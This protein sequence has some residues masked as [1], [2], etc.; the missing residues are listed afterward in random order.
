MRSFGMD[1]WIVRSPCTAVPRIRLFC[2][3]YAGGGTLTYRSWAKAL[4]EDVELCAVQLP[5]RE[6]RLGDPLVRSTSRMIDLLASALRRHIDRPFAFFGHSMGAVLAYEAARRL[7]A[8]TGHEPR[9]LVVSGHRPPH[10]ASHKPPLHGLPDE[11]FIAG[12]KA[13]NGTP[14]EIF[15]HADL[16]QLILPMLRAD[17][18]LIETYAEL[19]GPRLSCPVIALGG[20]ADTDVPIADIASWQSVTRGSFKSIVIPGD[21]FYVNTARDKLLEI[22]LNELPALKES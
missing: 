13:L 7:L 1:P 17:F 10:L 21:H 14:P 8:D 11:A 3:P 16:L 5:G 22:L 19:P 18:E 12:V 20:D 2:F 9:P 4:P 6:R 15:A